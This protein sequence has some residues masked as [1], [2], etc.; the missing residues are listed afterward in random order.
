MSRIQWRSQ[1]R[2][3]KSTALSIAQ[4]EQW[5]P[6]ENK[7]REIEKLLHANDVEEVKETRKTVLGCSRE[8]RGRKKVKMLHFRVHERVAKL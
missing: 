1:S 3:E 2:D 4:E 6:Q 5:K 7:K 8:I